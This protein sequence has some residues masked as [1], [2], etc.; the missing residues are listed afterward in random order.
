M[1]DILSKLLS[2]KQLLDKKRPLPKEL[3]KNLE[4][5]FRIELTYTSNAIEGNTLTRQETALV[6]EEGITIQG[7]TLEEQQE[8]VNHA[9]ALDFIKTLTIKRRVDITVEDILDIH[10]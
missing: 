9:N 3:I 8:A 5:W 1:N 10:R 4:E 7:K 6:V 2:K